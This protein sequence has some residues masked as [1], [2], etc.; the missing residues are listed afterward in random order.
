MLAAAGSLRESPSEPITVGQHVG[1]PGG[2]AAPESGSSND[3]DQCSLCPSPYSAQVPS[4]SNAVTHI[5]DG[6]SRLSG[7]SLEIPHLPGNSVSGRV[8]SH[9]QLSQASILAAHSRARRTSISFIVYG[10]VSRFFLDLVSVV[11][12]GF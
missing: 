6:S 3:E 11:F 8:D 1:G 10:L 12:I 5:Q 9:S 4:P 7:S 2:G